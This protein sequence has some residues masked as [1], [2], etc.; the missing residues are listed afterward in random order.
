MFKQTLKILQLILWTLDALTLKLII[1]VS[2]GPSHYLFCHGYV[3][4]RFFF[5][6]VLFSV[7]AFSTNLQD[8]KKSWTNLWHQ[9]ITMCHSYVVKKYFFAAVL[10][11]VGAFSKNPQHDKK[12][13]TNFWPQRITMERNDKKWLKTQQCFED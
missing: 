8:N 2:Q 7:G 11:P 9:R 4:L 5:A 3:V 6:T 12:S 1:K 10:L 13:W